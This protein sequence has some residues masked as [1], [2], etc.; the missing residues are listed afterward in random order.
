[1][2]IKNFSSLNLNC[3]NC[4]FK[5]C[6]E[7]LKEAKEK[8]EILKRC[9]Y[10]AKNLNRQKNIMP[11]ELEKSKKI[12]SESKWRDS[13]GRKFD[14]YLEHFPEDPGPRE[15]IVPHNPLLVSRLKIKKGDFIAGRPLGISCGCPI[16]HCGIVKKVEKETG[17]ITW[18]VTGPLSSQRGNFKNIGYYRAE[19][20]EGIVRVSRV[21]LKIGMRYFFQPRYCMLQWR[22]SGLINYINKLKDGVE[23][24]I[25][26]LWIG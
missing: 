4:G 26:G 25:E 22:H 10:L 20:Y 13:L 8:Q 24:R 3:G 15:I 9:T 6:K 17:L 2:N 19:S 18:C 11:F 16:T 1:M 14:F 23:V 5:S 12:D 7:F 21:N